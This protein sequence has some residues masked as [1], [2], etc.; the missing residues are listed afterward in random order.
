MIREKLYLENDSLLQRI[1]AIAEKVS[2]SSAGKIRYE[3]MIA[4]P[5]FGQ[6]ILRFDYLG[7]TISISQLDRDESWLREVAGEDFLVDFMGSVYS[8]AGADL[9]GIDKKLPV[10]AERY[11]GEKW[12]DPPHAPFLRE[13]GRTLLQEAGLDPSLPVWEIQTDGNEILLLSIG[14]ET[15]PAI[16]VPGVPGLSVG[17]VSGAACTGL[18]RAAL[19]AHK[20]HISLVRTLI[21]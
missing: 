15:R 10:L 9:S 16:E 6:I 17:I 21:E 14:Q 8:A 19:F 11:A 13:D 3:E 12:P 5:F 1:Y 2:V 4:L 20:N 18:Y 7:P